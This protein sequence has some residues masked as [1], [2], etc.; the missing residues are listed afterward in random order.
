MEAFVAVAKAQSDES[1]LSS[2]ATLESSSFASSCRSLGNSSAG[3][4]VSPGRQSFSH[5]LPHHHHHVADLSR[6]E[7]LDN[8][9][10]WKYLV[11]ESTNMVPQEPTMAANDGV[12]KT[13][14]PS[15]NTSA[16]A[17]EE[18][19]AAA[20]RSTSTTSNPTDTCST[21]KELPG[22]DDVVLSLATTANDEDGGR[23]QQEHHQH[24]SLLL[25]SSNSGGDETNSNV[26]R[27]VL[28]NAPT[29]TLNNNTTSKGP[30]SRLVRSSPAGDSGSTGSD[31]ERFDGKIV[32][33]PDG[34]AYIIEDSEMSEDDGSL[35]VPHLDGCIVDGRGV[36]FGQIPA[37]PQIANAIYVSRNPA[38]YNALYGQAYSSLLQDKKIVP[39]L[40]IMH[41]YRVYTIRDKSGD[42]GTAAAMDEDHEDDGEQEEEDEE[43]NSSS[44]RRERKRAG[45]CGL[46]GRTNGNNSSDVVSKDTSTKTAPTSECSSVPIKPI[47]MCFICKLSFGYTKSFIAHAMGDHNLILIDQEKD[48]LN[49]RNVSA[50][51]QPVGKNKDPT[52][53]FLEPTGNTNRGGGGHQQQQQTVVQSTPTTLVNQPC[54]TLQSL[55]LNRALHLHQTPSSIKNDL[56]QSIFRSSGGAGNPSSS[57]TTTT[58]ILNH[59]TSSDDNANNIKSSPINSPDHLLASPRP[60]NNS[61]NSSDIQSQ[62]NAIATP[63]SSSRLS[64]PGIDLTRKSPASGRSSA[65]PGA[66]ISPSPNSST[67]NPLMNSISPS[68]SQMSL[69]TSGGGGTGPPNFI[70]G[71]TIGVCPEHI[72]GRPSGVDCSKCEMILNSS[73]MGALGNLHTRNSCKTLKCP[74]CNWHYK[75]QE[76]LEIHMKEKHPDNET[77]CIYCIAGQPHPRLARGETYTCGYKP[78][79]CEVCNY[80][81]TTKGNLS[82]HMQSDKHLNNMQELQNGGVPPPESLVQQSAPSHSHKSMSGMSP[83]PGSSAPPPNPKP[84]P[85]FRCDVCNYETNVARNLRIHMTSE[86][87]THN[88]MVLQQNVKHMQ[89]LSALQQA[90]NPFDPAALLQFHPSLAGMGGGGGGGG[91]GSSD[92]QSPHAEA[93]IADMAYNQALL[94]QMMT[95]GQMP[96]HIPP[97]LAPHMDLGLN[98]DTMEPPPEPP[99]QNPSHLFQCCVCTV[100]VTDS[101]EALSHH[102][103]QDRTKLREQEILVLVAGNYMCKLCSYKTNLKANF[104]LHCKTDKHLQRLQ[105][106]NHVK[107]GGVR[108]EWKL[109]YLSMSNPVQVRCNACDYYTNSA[110]KLQLHAAHQRH[111]ISVLIFRHIHSHEASINEDCRIYACA[112]CGFTTRVKLQLLQHTRYDYHETEMIY[113]HI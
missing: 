38:L 93:A 6:R 105:H 104:Q 92:K 75:Y 70:T 3:S 87:H 35:D 34:S 41:S 33:N 39:D 47:L 68:G 74:K 103:T 21:N 82:I 111:E 10:Y 15:S 16:V 8:G 5:L 43:G 90:Q 106:V 50:I 67:P 81:T 32:Y 95:G 101:L 54:S 24:Q 73:R 62:A 94:I 2:G 91:S 84:K 17:G 55:S 12:S 64:N 52:I 77:S 26:T 14:S 40:P 72:N 42:R 57:S 51:I 36:S 44:L 107:E 27:S 20:V 23:L 56:P 18:T 45:G 61:N 48:V 46:G 113:I 108:N 85:T 98:P 86:K 11:G 66:N 49:Q 53:S 7:L 83:S 109:K 76:T 110:H 37:I 59:S 79:R 22:I 100:F 13:P 89:H 9:H 99:D 102:L 69:G 4:L 78:Y 1:Q 96:P 25:S 19:S 88:M 71:T 31:V 65:S 29:M 80:S 30:S 112:L 28:V 97:E 63:S 60:P 58:S